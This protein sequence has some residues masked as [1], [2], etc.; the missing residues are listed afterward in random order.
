M[1]HWG[2]AGAGGAAEVLSSAVCPVW[3]Q[4]MGPGHGAGTALSTLSSAVKSLNSTLLMSWMKNTEQ[5]RPSCG[6][7]FLH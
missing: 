1:S 5:T 3:G 7:K 4:D 6:A 2:Q